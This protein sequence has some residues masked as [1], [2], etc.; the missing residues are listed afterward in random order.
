MRIQVSHLRF[1]NTV[2]SNDAENEYEG[3]NQQ[4]N[5]NADNTFI[6]V[7]IKTITGLTSI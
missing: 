6:S 4:N 7:S 5:L 1:I 2:I 3:P